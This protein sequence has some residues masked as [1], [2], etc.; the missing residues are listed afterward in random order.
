MPKPI[1]NPTEDEPSA[2]PFRTGG[3]LRRNQEYVIFYFLVISSLCCEISA[4]ALG[5]LFGA[6]DHRFIATITPFL[7]THW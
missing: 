1:Q 4:A 2:L 3:R 6:Q 5:S 7:V